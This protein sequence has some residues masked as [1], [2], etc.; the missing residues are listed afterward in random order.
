MSCEDDLRNISKTAFFSKCFESFLADWLLPIVS[1][2][3][4]LKGGSISHYLLQLLKF[5]HEYLDLKT[6]HAVVFALVDQSK[7]FN[8]VSHSMVIEDLHDMHVP[9]WL[10]KILVSYLSGRSMTMRYKGVTSSVRFLPGSSP[11][12]GFLG[13]FLFIIKYNGAALRQ[14]VPRLLPVCDKKFSK[15][16]NKE[17]SVH[18]KQ[19]HAIYVDDLC[20]VAKDPEEITGIFQEDYKYKLKNTGPI[21]Y[22]LGCDFFRDSSG[23]LCLSPKTYIEKMEM[24]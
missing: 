16:F 20:I 3:F 19:T 4:G 5:T 7:A 9:P 11:Q 13:I 17:C 22:H 15:C 8:R 2:Q 14:S 12:G 1:P 21:S 24:T 6:P 10:L 23:T 18:L